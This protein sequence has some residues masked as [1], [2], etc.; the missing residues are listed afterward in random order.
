MQSQKIITVEGKD[1]LVIA[2][3]TLSELFSYGMIS[4]SGKSFVYRK[5]NYDKTSMSTYLN[6]KINQDLLKGRILNPNNSTH[7]KDFIK[8][9]FDGILMTCVK[10]SVSKI[11]IHKN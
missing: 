4:A 2:I 10:L 3:P 7:K 1:Y 8:V 9:D 6:V 5:W 11:L